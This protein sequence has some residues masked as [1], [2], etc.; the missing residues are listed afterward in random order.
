MTHGAQQP[1]VELFVEGVD[2]PLVDVTLDP[3]S[4]PKSLAWCWSHLERSVP[5]PARVQLVVTGYMAGSVRRW[6][7]EEGAAGTHTV[8]HGAGLSAGKTI[9]L[10]EGGAVVLLHAYYF[11]NDLDPDSTEANRLIARRVLVH[12]AQHVVMHQNRQVHQPGPGASFRDL[13]LVGGAAAIIEEYRA[14]ISVGAEFRRGEPRWE[15]NTIMADLQANLDAAVATYQGHR[16]LNRLV[17]EVTSSVLIGWRGLAYAAARESVLPENGGAGDVSAISLGTRGFDESWRAFAE[18]RRRVEPAGVVM[19]RHELE[20]VAADF[21]EIIRG[22]M[23]DLGF[24]WDDD[25]FAVAPWFVESATYGA[26]STGSLTRMQRLR[27]R[28]ARRPALGG[29][30]RG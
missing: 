12:E 14:E 7:P 6:S 26:A 18:V 27:A 16:S 10:P 23:V 2:L 25:A 24:R 4:V 11:R 9:R 3:P 28:W 13:N 22:S 8:E 1:L 5:D 19:P 21:A 30:L 15:A 29:S 20:A 17:F